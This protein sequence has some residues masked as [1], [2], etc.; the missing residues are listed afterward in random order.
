MT[1]GPKTWMA[2]TSPA[3]TLVDAY[4]IEISGVLLFQAVF[5][6]VEAG[7]DQFAAQ[8]CQRRLAIEHEVVEGVG[9]DL[10]HPDEA[11]LYVADE[12]QLHGAEQQAAAADHQPDLGNL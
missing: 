2:G 9:Q 10:G 4:R 12:E 5:E 1:E 6:D 11:G 8:Q 7:V 3:M